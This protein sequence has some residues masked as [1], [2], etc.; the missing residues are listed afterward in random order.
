MKKFSLLLLLQ[1]FSLYGFVDQDGDSQL[2]LTLNF[3]ERINKN[4]KAGLISE[5]RIGDDMSRPFFFFMQPQLYIRP[6]EWV[7]ITPGYRQI[8]SRYSRNR[9]SW[10]PTYSPMLDLSFLFPVRSGELS[11]RNR[12]QYLIPSSGKNRMLYR[13][14]IRFLFPLELPWLKIRPYTDNEIFYLEGIGLSQN[15]FSAGI[16]PYFTKNQSARLYYMLRLLRINRDWR[17]HNILGLEY[18]LTF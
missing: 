12:I 6:H 8:F 2:W 7:E 9:T 13:N 5:M 4:Y 10:L 17:T 18:F 14:R 16:L 3:Q 1:A 11:Q 15:R